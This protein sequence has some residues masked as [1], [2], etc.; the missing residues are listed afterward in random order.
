MSVKFVEIPTYKGM[1]EN[2]NLCV[3]LHEFGGRVF[4]QIIDVSEEGTCDIQTFEFYFDDINDAW[5]A[6]KRY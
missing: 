1:N 3:R 6:L 2:K 4:F 5:K